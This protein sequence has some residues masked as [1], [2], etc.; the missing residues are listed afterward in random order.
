MVPKKAKATKNYTNTQINQ[1]K[2]W[3]LYSIESQCERLISYNAGMH[4]MKKKNKLGQRTQ[5]SSV[6]VQPVRSIEAN[7]FLF[8]YTYIYIDRYDEDKSIPSTCTLDEQVNKR[9]KCP[10]PPQS[11][12][13]NDIQYVSLVLYMLMVKIISKKKTNKQTKCIT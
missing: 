8:I 1:G 7:L 13:T 2:L 11:R 5:L 12:S 9:K 10:F 4:E 3:S 6:K